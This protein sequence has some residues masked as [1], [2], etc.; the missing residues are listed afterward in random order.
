MLIEGQLRT[1]RCNQF[2]HGFPCKVCI[3]QEHHCCK[4]LKPAC[5][6]YCR[7]SRILADVAGVA[8][9]KGSHSE[10]AVPEVIGTNVSGDGNCTHRKLRMSGHMRVAQA[11]CIS[12][13]VAGETKVTQSDTGN[14]WGAVAWQAI[15]G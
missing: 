14:A 9:G 7:G 13:A 11:N 8:Y 3:R 4:G 15:P 1:H 5:I 2:L 6:W 12:G 10:T